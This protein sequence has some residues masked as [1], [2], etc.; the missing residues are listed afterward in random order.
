MFFINIKKC[1]KLKNQNDNAK[2]H[3]HICL[4]SKLFEIPMWNKMSLCAWVY[5]SSWWLLYSFLD[6]RRHIFYS[7]NLVFWF[8]TSCCKPC[9]LVY[10]VARIQLMAQTSVYSSCL[11]KQQL[12]WPIRKSYR[13]I[14]I[15]FPFL[16][17]GVR[18]LLL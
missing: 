11:A 1:K 18:T 14:K 13:S 6:K 4:C 16:F 5:D 10:P 9:K 17:F 15:G 7:V 12:E 3:M 2:I 8:V